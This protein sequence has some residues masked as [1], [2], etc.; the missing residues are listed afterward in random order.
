MASRKKTSAPA[1]ASEKKTKRGSS[2]NG[3]KKKNT[4]AQRETRTARNTA[5]EEQE[6]IYYEDGKLSTELGIILSFA[7]CAL[8]FLSNFGVIG[9]FG[10]YLSAFTLGL[11]GVLGYLAP[12]AIFIGVCFYLSN[13]GSM[14]AC[15]RLGGSVLFLWA[16]GSMIQLFIGE[17]GTGSPA[18]YYL[19]GGAGGFFGGLLYMAL[20]AVVGGVGTFLILT[21]LMAIGCVLVTGKSLV[22]V[23]REKSE[24]TYE[25]AREDISRRR[26]MRAAE[27]EIREAKRLEDQ[28]VRGVNLE[29]AELRGATLSQ[30]F[31]NAA[32]ELPARRRRPED[33]EFDEERILGRKEENGPEPI[34]SVTSRGDRVVDFPSPAGES[35]P[36]PE[37]VPEVSE[38]LT[39]QSEE[40]DSRLRKAGEV[41]AAASRAAD[42]TDPASVFRGKIRYSGMNETD[43]DSASASGDMTESDGPDA[44]TGKTGP[45][46]RYPDRANEMTKDIR[47]DTPDDDVDSEWE[48]EPEKQ[49]DEEWDNASGDDSAFSAEFSSKNEKEYAGSESW[50]GDDG[51]FEE[52]EDPD[53]GIRAAVRYQDENRSD[54]NIL[55]AV[56]IRRDTRTFEEMYSGNP[57][58]EEAARNHD[59]Q[60]GE[61]ETFDSTA[62]E[63]ESFGREAVSSEIFD[64]TAGSSETSDGAAGSSETL[65]RADETSGEYT[66]E[67][68][69]SAHDSEP[70]DGDDEE[71]EEENENDELN[72]ESD[73]NGYDTEEDDGFSAAALAVNSTARPNGSPAPEARPFSQSASSAIPASS[74]YDRRDQPV[75]TATG[76]VLPPRDPNADAILVKKAALE[77][78]AD[79]I[80]EQQDALRK[81]ADVQAQLTAQKEMQPKKEYVFPP[82]SLLRKDMRPGG[83]FDASYYEDTAVKLQQTLKNFGVG[84]TVTNISCGPTVT[85]YELQPDMGVK[86]SRI[87]ALQD[88]IKLN[89]AAA[90]IR[91]EAPI[92][93]KA[94]IGIEVPNKEQ[95]T[96]YLRE[97]LESQEFSKHKSRV[98]FA[99]GKD[100]GGQTV[101][102]DVAKMPHLLI[103]G[104]TGSGKSVC[105]NT[106]IMSIIYKAKPEEVKMIMIDPK[107]V[108]LSVYNGIPHLLIPVVTDPKKAAGALNWAVQEMTERYNTFAKYNVRDIKGY[109]ARV[110]GISDLEGE[111]KPKKMP[112]II[113][114]VDE[115]A[116]LMMVAPGDVEEAICRLAQLAR[117]AGIHLVIATQR[118]SVNVITGVIK[119]NIPSRIA[120]SVSSG[121]DSRTIIDM[122]GAEKL[123]GKGD[124]LFYPSGY[125]KP[126]RVQGA[127]VSDEEVGEVVRYLTDEGYEAEYADDI[128]SKISASSVGSFGGG[129]GE[130]DAYFEQAARFII[131]KDKASIG[132]LQRMFKIGF[133]RA[134]RIM[135][136]LEEAGVVAGEQGTKPREILMSMEQFENSMM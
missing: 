122:N 89:L 14:R 60:N 113:I 29:A 135:D 28:N 81:A 85:R 4:A 72:G 24:S 51:S 125:P 74:S 92:P 101:V 75:I 132:M 91:I 77:A 98:A 9:T 114:I 130:R 16:L 67:N 128:E 56:Y 65:D 105:I 116:D 34:F 18:D 43:E 79:K 94:A 45:S 35:A 102:T 49:T 133:N 55:K 78:K 121:V 109:N 131:E 93:G 127:F 46:P 119:A 96:V 126:K 26:E 50:D 69:S 58:P 136:Q 76:A 68:G 64:R 37:M 63:P 1:E 88:D 100:I 70:D 33:A 13:N 48:T 87:L 71:A 52:E 36:S 90:D 57:L 104:A 83:E 5:E 123:L 106:L 31:K 23:V 54:D 39:A 10:S 27:R 99:V 111:E 17:A 20:H 124:M 7:L 118:P 8:F 2:K 120:F 42:E 62:G 112:Q 41:L 61:P 115:L 22:K 82:L 97:L 53:E 38:H 129:G 30:S 84:V 6:E 134:A 19:Q 103:A 32:K 3:N 59:W 86:V 117:A 95:K 15:V 44:G 73:E 25:Y 66:F 80:R 47:R 12:I 107:V 21:A 108:E 110:D 40:M 11:F